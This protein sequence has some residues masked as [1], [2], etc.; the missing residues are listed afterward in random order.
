MSLSSSSTVQRLPSMPWKCVSCRH[1]FHGPVDR[2]PEGGC[3]ACG[4]RQII[5]CNV[6]PVAV[7]PAAR[8]AEPRPAAK[9]RPR[10]SPAK[11][12]ILV[13]E[14]YEAAERRPLSGRDARALLRRAA[15]EIQK[16]QQLPLL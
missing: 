13:R 10:P 16:L 3:P 12:A 6:Q 14:L 4:S 11:S 2:A 5:D 9:P 7:I 8:L 15:D 1:D